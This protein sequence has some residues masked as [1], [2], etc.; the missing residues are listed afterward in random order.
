[1]SNIIAYIVLIFAV[2]LGTAA[3]ENPQFLKKACDEY[4]NKIAL[5]IDVR[6]GF[7]ALSGWKKQTNIFAL[8]F[9]KKINGN[10]FTTPSSSV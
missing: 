8:D 9:V 4:K 6:K 7:I 5:S 2:I 10:H 1:M 3:I